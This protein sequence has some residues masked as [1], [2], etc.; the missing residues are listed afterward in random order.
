MKEGII[1]PR[2]GIDS[3]ADG[4]LVILG[5]GYLDINYT[6]YQILIQ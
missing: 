5:D 6:W 3:E 4:V 1:V 2:S